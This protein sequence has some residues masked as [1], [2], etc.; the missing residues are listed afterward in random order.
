M[1]KPT[2][3]IRESTLSFN[4]N[5]EA[6]SFVREF[7][8]ACRKMS[9]YGVG[10]PLALKAVEK[11]FFVLSTVFKYKV[12]VNLNMRRGELNLLNIRLKESPFSAQIIQLL[13]ALD[14]NALL[15]QRRM[16]INDFGYF[17]QTMVD[18][19]SRCKASGSLA[20]QLTR[21]EIDTIQVNSE[22]GYHL[23]EDRKQYRGD[24]DGDFSVKRLALDQLGDDPI[25]LARVHNA[26]EQGLL[27]NGIDFDPAIIA[28]L[29][30]EK[31]AS[32][33]AVGV[34]KVL[35]ELADQI[36]TA[37][38]GPKRAY[39]ATA[40][41]MA[42]FKLVEYHPEKK[43]ITADLDERRSLTTKQ[44]EGESFT[45]TGAI[46]VQTS[47][48]IDQLLECFFSAA[49]EQVEP[50]A[51][52][53]AFVRLLKTG[54][55]PKA[56]EVISRLLDLMSAPDPDCRQRALNL[57]GLATTE[58]GRASDTVILDKV[59]ADTISRLQAGSETYEYSEFLWQLFVAFQETC[60]YGL[61][62][63]LTGAM[64]ARRTV[65]G[66]VTVY[67][68]M[69]VKKGFENIGRK[70]TVDALVQGL[71]TAGGETAGY[72]KDTLVAVGSEE[73]ALAL[74]QII[75]HPQRSVRQLTLKILAELGKSSLRVFS[76][77]LNDDAMFARDH[78]RHEL[79]DEK[80][81]V[82]RNSIFVLGSL[83]DPQ[84]VAPLRAR[85][86]DKDVRVR[87]EI[88]A[89]LEKIGGEEA[90]DCFTLMAEDP[91]IEVRE[92][93]VVAIGLTGRPESAPIL[94]DISKKDP[95]NSIKAVTALGKLGGPEAREFMGKL[96]NDPEATSELSK[97]VV[98]K[99]DLRVAAVKA[100]GQIGDSDAIEHVR[101]FRDGQSTA[102]K[103]LF[104]NSAVNKAVV[105]VM[106]RH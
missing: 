58:L 86:D 90:I 91:I 104:K 55:Q 14:V 70:T 66:N 68:S 76:R 105:E 85:I 25:H 73:I 96:L 99:D 46:K 7:A 97:G 17:V 63:R 41:Y 69:A 95:R 67:D 3:P 94:I 75:S 42:L 103:L 40:D 59:A 21:K 48:Q 22:L 80:W 49:P 56:T 83:R 47:A 16:R 36:N 98:S 11:P 4:L 52:A 8:M 60:R 92:A 37:G 1:N 10:H 51:F 9:I 34:R 84:G 81:Y 61:A 27:D 13:Q 87:R 26:N 5:D 93:A 106:S 101:K 79:P 6:H 29:M 43:K 65:D 24:V 54:Q 72:L 33:D 20:E 12:F 23:F 89:A 57:L 71:I 62:A 50:D 19:Q 53:D 102:Q 35:I 2:S 32:F 45:E 39:E 88:V 30:P 18:R 64:A 100:L 74:S 82:I 15:F 77:I 28:Y 44:D 78:T 38:S 31:M